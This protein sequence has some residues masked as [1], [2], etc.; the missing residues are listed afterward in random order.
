[1][2]EEI[3]EV[4]REYNEKFPIL[5]VIVFNTS[6]A[7]IINAL[8]KQ[9]YVDSLDEVTGEEIAV[10]WAA[11]PEGRVELPSL[12]PG[13]LGMMI[14]IYKEPP[15]NRSLYEF[16]DIKDGQSLPLLVTFSFDQDE[17]LHFSKTSLLD[18]GE[19][20][21]F[22]HLKRVLSEKASLLRDF[23]DNLKKDRKKMFKELELFDKTNEA[24]AQMKK[25]LSEMGLIR[26]ATGM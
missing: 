3:K 2:I 10:F 18:G 17:T 9:T 21:A 15:S 7:H 16:F 1:M 22:N 6:H 19:E 14:P 11:L 8:R 25:F 24:T 23:S 13:C 5:A 12:P 4:S 20:E 26:S